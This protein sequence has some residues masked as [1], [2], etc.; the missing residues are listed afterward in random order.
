LLYSF[1]WE[2]GFTVKNAPRNT[3]EVVSFRKLVPAGVT[4]V[5]SERIK[6]PGT[7][8]GF[9]I[10]FYPGQQLSLKVWVVIEHK[11]GLTESLVT[12]AE[13]SDEFLSGDDDRMEF[14]VV[15]SVENDDFLKIKVFNSDMVN[16][17][18]LAVDV[19]IDYYG[20]T[21]RVIGGLL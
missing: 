21:Q 15:A 7:V 8:E 10:R 13:T 14:D 12:F 11:G 18:N 19:T 20:G 17:Y 4:D 16:D 6:G 2:R 3:K 9:R 1:I 5:L